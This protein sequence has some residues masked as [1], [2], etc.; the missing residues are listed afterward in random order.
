VLQLPAVTSEP[1]NDRPVVSAQEQAQMVADA[2]QN[3]KDD[4]GPKPKSKAKAKATAKAKGSTKSAPKAKAS[5]KPAAKGK[6]KAAPVRPVAVMRS[7]QRPLEP[8]TVNG[9]VLTPTFRTKLYPNGCSKCR[10][11]SGCTKSCWTDRKF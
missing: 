6:A 7:G 1:M 10:F 3:R 8:F 11:R 5:P 4:K 2:T 9:R